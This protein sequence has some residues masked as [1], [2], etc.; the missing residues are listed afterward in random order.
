MFQTPNTLINPIGLPPIF[1]IFMNFIPLLGVIFF[2][3]NVFALI[4][5]FWLETLAM[6]FFD[7]LK[8]FTSSH[9]TDFSKKLSMGLSF[10]F[11]RFFILMFYMIFI[12]A[13]IGIMMS[14]KQNNGYEWVL[15]LVLAVPRFKITIISFFLI[16]LYEYIVYYLNNENNRSE[17]PIKYN[18]VLD[19]RV[20]VIHIVI[21]LGFFAFQFFDEKSMTKI[22]FVA[23]TTIFIAFKMLLDRYANK[24]HERN[25]N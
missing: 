19:G 22:G 17:D 25:Y 13:F 21:I 6:T 2:D 3:W 4:Y 12:L 9:N 18:N 7:T 20:L 23:F 24:F 8:I 10:F 11:I 14:S 5:I 16:K 1:G 15:Y